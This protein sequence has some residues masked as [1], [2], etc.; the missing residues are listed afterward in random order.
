MR[1]YRI[2]VFFFLAAASIPSMAQRGS[3][4]SIIALRAKLLK[5]IALTF[6]A[7]PT[8][9]RSGYDS[10]VIQALIETKT[11]ATLFLSGLWVKKHTRQTQFLSSVSLFEIANHSY[12]HPHLKEASDQ[13]T[14]TEIQKTNELLMKL[15]CKKPAFFRPPYGEFDERTQRLV[16]EAGMRLIEYDVASGDPDTTIS[17]QRLV[18]HVVNSVKNGSIV[19]MHMNKQGRHTAE[20]L[21]AII[22]QLRE[23]GYQFVKVSEL[24]SN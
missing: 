18:R 22:S 6:D 14:M 21:P 19:I 10:L 11:P 24:E 15:G 3:P 23:K 9:H 2:L 4:S 20:A 12:S 7:C 5:R 8:H 17:T 13:V 16:S 1:S